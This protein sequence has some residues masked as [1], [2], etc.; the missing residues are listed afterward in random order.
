MIFK[1]FHLQSLGHASYFVGSEETGE[2][3]VLDA[4]R[5]VDVYFQAARAQ[6]MRIKYAL[7]THQHNDYVTGITELPK[8]GEIQLL[9]SARAELGY[10]AKALKDGARVEMGEVVFEVLAT[11][12]HTPEHISLLVTDRSRGKEPALLLSGGALLVGDV[13]RPDLLGGKEE[14]E[15]HAAEMCRTLQEKILTLPDFVEVYPT[16]VAGSLCG[17]SIGSRLST[18]VGYERR[19]NPILAKL[20]QQR[21]FVEKC[22]NLK[23]LPAVPPYWPSMRKLNKEGPAPLGTLA[24]PAALRPEDFEKSANSG[25][26][27]LDCRSADAFAAH[28]P[29]SLNVGIG[30]SFPTWAGHRPA[31]Q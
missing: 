13:A 21:E 3:L 29:K 23:D 18:T 1:Q 30:S 15:K 27:I 16:H 17:G 31:A 28:V 6:N 10:R 5:D 14:S 26:V 20:D 11:P 8:R 25:A 12:G 7:D 19:M 4:R 24:E 9:A 22:L 2:A